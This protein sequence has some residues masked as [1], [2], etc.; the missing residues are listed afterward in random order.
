M[1]EE[2]FGCHEHMRLFYATARAALHGLEAGLRQRRDDM[3]SKLSGSAAAQ[4][5]LVGLQSKLAASKDDMLR[6]IAAKR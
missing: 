3:A 4:M 2:V 6:T 1:L 5:R